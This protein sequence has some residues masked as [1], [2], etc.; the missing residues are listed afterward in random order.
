MAAARDWK[1]NLCVDDWD[2]LWLQLNNWWWRKRAAALRID[3]FCEEIGSALADDPET[4][5]SCTLG[6]WDL[7]WQTAV[8]EDL[9]IGC[10]YT[11]HPRVRAVHVACQRFIPDWIEWKVYGH[12]GGI[13]HVALLSAAGPVDEFRADIPNFEGGAR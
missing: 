7:I 12:V 5:M 10:F 4:V 8:R 1:D 6:S 13:A 9:D 3:R 2:V 11:E